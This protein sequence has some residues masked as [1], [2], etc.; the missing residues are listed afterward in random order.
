MNII[1]EHGG[2]ASWKYHEDDFKEVSFKNHGEF[3]RGAFK[4][5]LEVRVEAVLPPEVAQTMKKLA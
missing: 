4:K 5:W 3:A 2:C 1:R